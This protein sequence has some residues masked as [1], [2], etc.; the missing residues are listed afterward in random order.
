MMNDGE[1]NP[2]GMLDRLNLLAI[3]TLAGIVVFLAASLTCIILIA[4]N[5]IISEGL[6]IF[7]STLFAADL[8]VLGVSGWQAIQRRKTEWEPSQEAKDTIQLNRHLDPSKPIISPATAEHPLPTV[9]PPTPETQPAT[10][11]HPI[12]QAGVRP[13]NPDVRAGMEA[14]ADRPLSAAR[15]PFGGSSQ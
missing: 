13:S 7:A 3:K 5:G 15:T 9:I 12:P 2:R 8:A 10:S 11:E 1:S 14:I 4:R 6:T